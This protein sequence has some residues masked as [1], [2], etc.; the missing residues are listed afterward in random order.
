[1]VDLAI[2]VAVGLC[3]VLIRGVKRRLEGKMQI[4]EEIQTNAFSDI[5]AGALI[6][7]GMSA[8]VHGLLSVEIFQL[9]SSDLRIILAFSGFM[10]ILKGIKYIRNNVIGPFAYRN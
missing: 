6:A 10:F 2:P 4:L 8:L 1:M 3:V 5:S 9:D 7:I